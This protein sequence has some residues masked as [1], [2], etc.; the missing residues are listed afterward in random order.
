M[1]CLKC[2]SNNVTIDFIEVGSK[3]SKH[4][5]GLVGHLNNTARAM[6]GIATLGLSNLV[7]KKSKGGESTKSLTEKVCL[8]QNCGH[9]WSIK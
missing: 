7:W 2:D 4:E 8:C 6:T 1:N 5:N 9:S 3:T